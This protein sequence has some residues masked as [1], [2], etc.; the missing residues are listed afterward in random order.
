[1]KKILVI[2][3]RQTPERQAAERAAYA[4]VAADAATFTFVSTLD[5]EQSWENPASI[6]HGYDGVII[7]GSSD[8]FLHG[9]KDEADATR[10]GAREVLERV[11]FLAEYLV[12]QQVPTL[13]ICFG[14][15]L[16]AEV[17]GGAVTH[18]HSQKK[19][20]THTVCLTEAGKNDALFA[21]LPVEFDAQY[22]H[23]DSVTRPPFGSVTLATGLACQFAALRYGTACYTLQF[24][25]ELEARDFLSQPEALKP[26]MKE[27]EV[28]T[29][30]VRESPQTERLI[31]GFIEAIAIG[32]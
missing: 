28:V 17:F 14:H 11:R 16:I 4:R 10:T 31:P 18:D 7:G 12:A 9:G 8:F 6:V 1:M 30:I 32:E 2:Q 27:R 23:R 5:V 22:A 24:H 13:G 3:S 21:K 29:D 26:Y 15:Q 20:G 19:A 25:P